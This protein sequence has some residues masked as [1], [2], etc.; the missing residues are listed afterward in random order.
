MNHL[1]GTY[2]DLGQL[3]RAIS[4]FGQTLELRRVKLGED[5]PDT[6]ISKNNLAGAYADAGQV[7]RNPTLRAGA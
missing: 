3:D 2:Q 4:L 7:E 1:A 5:H 6:L